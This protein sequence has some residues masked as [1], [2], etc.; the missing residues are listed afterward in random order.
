MHPEPYY[1]SEFESTIRNVIDELCRKK[2]VEFVIQVPSK[3]TTGVM[4][5]KVRLNQIFINLLSNAVKFTPSGG[6]VEFIISGIEECVENKVLIRCIVRDNGIGMSKEFIPHA[7]ENFNQEYRADNRDRSEG[8]GLGLPIVKELVRLMNGTIALESELNKGTTFTVDIPLELTDGLK[9][10]EKK[11]VNDYSVLQDMRILL[12]EDNEINMEIAKTLLIK[13]GCVVDH[14]ENGEEACKMF[15]NTPTGFYHAILMDIRMP[16][17]NGYE[18]TKEIRG[19][20]REDAKTVPI[21][22]TTADAFNSDVDA[23]TK[24]GMNAH[25]A[26]PIDPVKLYDALCSCGDGW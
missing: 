24:A 11:Q 26:K 9:E 12:V 16:I 13:K 4:V 15:R 8:T 5:D 2:D 17:M 19:M 10:P 14:A 22:A 18:A 3:P 1:L 6:K 7:F 25:I 20:K 23:V 21:I